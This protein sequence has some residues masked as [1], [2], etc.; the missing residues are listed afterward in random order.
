[1][2]RKFH[3]RLPHNF[4]EATA[5]NDTSAERWL[6]EI[7][8]RT[9]GAP[10]E[11]YQDTYAGSMKSR[12]TRCCFGWYMPMYVFDCFFV[13]VL[14]LLRTV[15]PN[16]GHTAKHL[17]LP[18][19]ADHL[20]LVPFNPNEVPLAKQQVRSEPRQLF[21]LGFFW[22][23]SFLAKVAAS[24]SGAYRVSFGLTVG[25]RATVRVVLWAAGV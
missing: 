14:A 17:K 8:L 2:S 5:P 3:D 13:T 22:D 1:M 16:H 19:R 7:P 15:R 21:E 20:R 9:H 10:R 25:A 18:I 24:L 4:E 23:G 6:D 12:L 11:S